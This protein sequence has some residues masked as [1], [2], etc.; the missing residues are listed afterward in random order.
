MSA[1]PKQRLTPEGYLHLERTASFRSEYVRGEVFA[2]AGANRNHNRI[3]GNIYHFLRTHLQNKR[4]EAFIHDM[5]V[6][7][8]GEEYFY[9]D[10]VVACEKIHYLD[11]HQDTILN[12]VVIFEILSKSTGDYDRS[13]KFGEYR[14]A[15]SLKDDVVVSQTRC[16]VE[17][18]TRQAD[19]RW[20]LT[21]I[22]L[23]SDEL[24]LTGIPIAIP[25]AVIYEAISFN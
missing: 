4:C 25:L 18:H 23:P 12:P 10:V 20:L 14:A 17:H 6:S 13:G 21:D 19:G 15:A 2:M 24:K 22:V 3:A 16:H 11:E 5:R 1:A 7:P 8:A 9:P